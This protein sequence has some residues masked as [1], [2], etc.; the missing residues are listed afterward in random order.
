M[1][2]V[3]CY[4]IEDVIEVSADEINRSPA[5]VY[6]FKG[7]DKISQ[8]FYHTTTKQHINQWMQF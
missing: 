1:I 2:D 6:S 5:K 4:I 3:S 7:K 8:L